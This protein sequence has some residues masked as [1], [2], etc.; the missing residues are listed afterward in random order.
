MLKTT[1]II[2]CG[3]RL[4]VPI[5]NNEPL[6]MPFANWDDW[7]DSY[8]GP[9]KGIGDWLVP[10]KFPRGTIVTPCCYIHDVAGKLC[11]T[12]EEFAQNDRMFCKN[13]VE[14]V[15]AH[16]PLD[17]EGSDEHTDLLWAISYYVGVDNVKHKRKQQNKVS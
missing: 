6:Q 5:I 13:M 8:C 4:E 2:Y 9:G 12:F 7:K 1:F 10:E 15:F 17:V 16:H 3:R 14:A 11:K